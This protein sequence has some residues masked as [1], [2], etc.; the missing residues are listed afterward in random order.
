[1]LPPHLRL[2]FKVAEEVIVEFIKKTVEEAGAEGV[3]L[4]ISGGGDSA[5]VATLAA[6]A[7]GPKRVKGVHLPDLETSKI[8]SAIAEKVARILGIDFTVLNIT[9]PVSDV[10]ELLGL[11][12]F[13]APKVPKGNVK[14]RVRATIIY[15]I[16]N[17]ENRLVAGTSDRSEWLIGY[18]TKWGD[19][20]GDIYPIV[21]LF[22]TQV[23]E[24]GK[25]LG[26]PPEVT[27]R[28]PTPDLWPG[29]T[30]EG[31]LGI[32]YDLIDEVLYR[33]FDEG[34]PP[35]EVPNVASIPEEVVKKVM[36]LHRRSEHKRSPFKAPFKSFKELMRR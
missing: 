9:K 2:D 24:F 7:L 19:M 34:I 1:M 12:Y 11:D 28:P 26:L 22:K 33:V 35:E 32:T 8:S 14:V 18:F 31:E 36:E 13:K 25:Y 23:R 3:V 29:H 21:G 6:R 17:L 5:V 4:G 27:S 16:A 15:A 20:A 30:A 10:L